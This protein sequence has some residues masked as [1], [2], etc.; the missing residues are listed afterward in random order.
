MKDSI[1]V[2]LR[3]IGEDKSF[4]TNGIDLKRGDKV[5]VEADRGIDHGRVAGCCK[6]NVVETT[7]RSPMRK[8]I[9]KVNPWDEEQIQKNEKKAKDLM[10]I[11]NKKIQ[12]RKLPMKLIQAEYS[13]DRSKIVFYF[14]S[15]SRV[16]FRGLVRDLASIFRVRIELRQIGVRDEARIL[17]GHACCG[18]ELCC[19]SFLKK[20][21]PVTIKM[22]KI[23]NLPLNQSKISGLCGRL[24]CCLGYEYQNYKGMTKG[25]PKK[26]KEIK[27]DSGKGRVVAV[28]PLKRIVT[29]DMGEKGIKNIKI[30]E[31]E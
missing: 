28:N 29:V 22:A 5:I 20:F 14:T 1:L 25:L 18:R 13:F 4:V 7:K 24:M 8:I 15:E 27:T 6:H 12:E 10:N 9:R 16:D 19:S 3:A 31:N 26:G 30:E 23:Q 2:H 21:D 17:G 11:C